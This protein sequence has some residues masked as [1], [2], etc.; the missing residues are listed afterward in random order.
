MDQCGLGQFQ[1]HCLHNNQSCLRPMLAS[2]ILT[3]RS[4][5]SQQGLGIVGPDPEMV[6][7]SDVPEVVKNQPL[8]IEKENKNNDEEDN[9]EASLLGE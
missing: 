2:I 5:A 4:C 7:D 6:D 3:D 8:Q 1:K 9:R